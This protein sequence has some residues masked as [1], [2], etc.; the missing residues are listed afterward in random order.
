MADTALSAYTDLTLNVTKFAHT[1]FL[2]VHGMRDGKPHVFFSQNKN[3]FLDNVHF[4]HSALLIEALQN[5]DIQFGL[6]VR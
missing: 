4:Q 6:M 1:K 5:A 3:V 2:L